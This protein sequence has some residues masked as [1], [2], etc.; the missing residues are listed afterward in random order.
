MTAQF[1]L[2]RS[3]DSAAQD[4]QAA[5]SA[6]SGQLPQNLPSPP[7]Y[8]KVNPA[9]PP[10]IVLGVHSDTLPITE[11]DDYAENMLALLVEETLEQLGFA[12][13]DGSD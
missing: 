11:V 3:A 10:I 13:H 8:R 9:D 2:T 7:S 12:V 1:D 5:I 4:V 6:A